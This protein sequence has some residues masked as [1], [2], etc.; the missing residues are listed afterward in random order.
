MNPSRTAATARQLGLTAAQ[1]A[2]LVDA[3]E[4]DIAAATTST[5]KAEDAAW[6]EGWEA[7]AAG[8]E[9]L[10]IEVN[11]RIAEQ[12]DRAERLNARIDDLTAWESRLA[13]QERRLHA[14]RADLA[15]GDRTTRCC[16]CCARPL[17]AR[18]RSD[19]RFCGDAC[20]KR[21]HRDRSAAA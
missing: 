18:A 8:A 9:E 12:N 1:I 14:E 6:R 11:A 19:S 7:A 5:A 15:R 10:R 13:D 16:D 4:A 21:A 17:P 20:R 3:A 2:E